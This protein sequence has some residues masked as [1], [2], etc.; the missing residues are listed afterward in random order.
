MNDPRW[1]IIRNL[2]TI[3]GDIGSQDAREALTDCLQHPD[4]RVRKEA[5]RALA[6]LGGDEAEETIL[7]IL[8]DTDAALYSQ[9][10][11]SL[12]WMKSTKALSE[13]I[14][15]VFSRDLFLKSLPL[16]IDA[17]AAIAAIGDPQVTPYLASL[18]EERFLLAPTR[19]RQ[20]KTAV[21][22]CLGKLGDDRAVPFLEA[23]A[24]SNGE[25]ASACSSALSLIEKQRKQ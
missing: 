21:A 7:A 20:L 24:S 5:V 18:L 1:F 2:C 12:G 17:L 4:L 14:I 15:F 9:A 3:L 25:L 23:H 8:R 19:G 6:K 22:V 16:K 10:I 13:L 11:A